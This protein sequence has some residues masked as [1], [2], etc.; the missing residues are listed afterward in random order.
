MLLRL[1]QSNNILQLL[2]LLMLLRV[3]LYGLIYHIKMMELD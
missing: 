1:G 3:Q 2:M